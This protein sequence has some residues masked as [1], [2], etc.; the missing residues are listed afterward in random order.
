[1]FRTAIATLAA[2]AAL[3]TGVSVAP[4]PL[5]SAATG[6]SGQTAC[7][8]VWAALPSAM[9]DDIKAAL[10]LDGQE[11]H[12]A[13]VAVRYGA[14]HGTYGDRVQRG[15]RALQHRRH[16]IWRTLPDQLK[17]DVRAARSLPWPE[18][19][20]AFLTI[21]DNALQGAYGDRVQQLVERR[22][23]FLEGCPDEI[24]SYVD[25]ETDPLAG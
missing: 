8:R 12:R 19:R 24:R 3:A 4:S 9:Q 18:R 5:V 16:E 22:Q 15:A 20:E 21:R 2:S 13:L 17:A 23:A 1:M 25:E 6:H 14:L 10:S 7:E 11:Q